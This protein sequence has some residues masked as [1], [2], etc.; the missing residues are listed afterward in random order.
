MHI[1][2]KFWIEGMWK[3]L[4]TSLNPYLS[5]L[6][7]CWKNNPMKWGVMWEG[8]LDKMSIIE[9]ILRR[10]CECKECGMPSDFVYTLLNEHHRIYNGEKL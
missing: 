10:N 7:Q 4:S 8:I 1:K 3:V 6:S 2:E 5:D 9:C